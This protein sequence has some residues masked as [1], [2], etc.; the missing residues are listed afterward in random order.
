[1]P[2]D[3]QPVPVGPEVVGVVNGPARQPEDLPFEFG[4][5][6]QAGIGHRSAR[7]AEAEEPGNDRSAFR[8]RISG[9]ILCLF[10]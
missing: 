2:T 8:L 9:P 6:R 5:V 7:E 10:D 3:L 4:Q 1:M